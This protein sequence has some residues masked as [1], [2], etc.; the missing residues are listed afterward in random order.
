MGEQQMSYGF[1]KMN[2]EI[3]KFDSI[4]EINKIVLNQYIMKKVNL[5]RMKGDLPEGQFK[6]SLR[7]AEKDLDI[8]KSTVSRI[9][10]EFESKNIVKTINKSSSSG[11]YSVYEYI[12]KDS[13]KTMQKTETPYDTVSGSKDTSSKQ[14]DFKALDT[15]NEVLDGTGCG[16]YDKTSNIE[17]INKNN[18]YSRVVDYLNKKTNK[19]FRPQTAKTK[20]MI[21]ARLNEGFVEEDFYKVIDTKSKQWKNTS[22]EKYLRPET[23]FSDKFER[24]LNEAIQDI[25]LKEEEEQKEIK[26]YK[27][28]FNF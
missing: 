6:F 28:D 19:N 9:L 3:L 12:V 10:N 17:N 13:D 25:N 22:I 5:H 20:E 2:I 1:C 14:S 23:L 8:S 18:I 26:S 7:T 24:Y 21:L 15:S 4:K 11:A 16:T 27:I